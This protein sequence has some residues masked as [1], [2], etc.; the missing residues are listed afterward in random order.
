MI[1]SLRLISAGEISRYLKVSNVSMRH[2][3]IIVLKSAVGD[4]YFCT[5]I[6]LVQRLESEGM[7]SV[8]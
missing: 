7:P 3:L 4:R 8:S 2:H 5:V 1:Y 6:S